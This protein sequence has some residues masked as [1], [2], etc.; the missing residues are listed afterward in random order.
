M[1]T[2]V[3]N[4]NAPIAAGVTQIANLVY[5][6]GTTPPVC[7]TTPGPQCVITPTPGNVTIAKALDRRDRYAN[8]HR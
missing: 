5:E 3:T 6:T 7:T 8:G 4:V 1:L 2:V